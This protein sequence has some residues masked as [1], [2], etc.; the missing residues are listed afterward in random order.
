MTA[1]PTCRARGPISADGVPLEDPAAIIQPYQDLLTAYG[2]TAEMRRRL[3]MLESVD[4]DVDYVLVPFAMGLPDGLSPEQAAF[5]VGLLSDPDAHAVAE[6]HERLCL[7]D[8]VRPWID[9]KMAKRKGA[10]RG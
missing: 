7:D 4:P 2:E 8:D 5:L 3:E 9:A 1:T 10:S 6:F